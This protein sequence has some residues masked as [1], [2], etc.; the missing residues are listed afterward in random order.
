MPAKKPPGS[1]TQTAD[2]QMNRVNNI[3]NVSRAISRMQRD[4]DQKIA[5]TKK[6]VNEGREFKEIHDTMNKTLGSLNSTIGALTGGITRITAD[7]ARATA[8]AIKQYGQAISQDIS[9]NKKNVVAMALAQT[10]P[11]YGYFVA[12]FME[13]D[14]FKRALTRM[15]T[16]IGQTIGAVVRPFKGKATKGAEIPHMQK[17]GTVKAGGLAKLHAGETVIP[18]GMGSSL[19]EMVRLQKEQSIYL[20]SV[21]GSVPPTKKTGLFGMFAKTLATP[22]KI[23]KY[24]RRRKGNYTSDLSNANMPL[25]NIAQNVATLYTQLMWRLDN[26]LEI[27]KANVQANRDLATH[28]TG[29]GYEPIKGISFYR[30]KKP[31]IRTALSFI[32]RRA[33]QLAA[34]GGALALLTGAPVAGAALGGAGIGLGAISGVLKGVAKRRAEKGE[35]GGVAGFLGKERGLYKGYGHPF[36]K[37]IGLGIKR[38]YRQYMPTVEQYKEFPGWEEALTPGTAFKHFEPESEAAKGGRRKM[39]AGMGGAPAGAGRGGELFIQSTVQHFADVLSETLGGEK[40]KDHPVWTIRKFTRDQKRDLNATAEREKKEFKLQKKATESVTKLKDVQESWYAK[41]KKWRWIDKL[42]KWGG[43]L[44]SFISIPFKGLKNLFGGA[45]AGVGLLGPL[46]KYLGIPALIFGGL[47]LWDWLDK[48]YPRGKENGPIGSVVKAIRESWMG[49][50]WDLGSSITVSLTTAFKDWVKGEKPLGQIVEETMKSVVTDFLDKRFLTTFGASFKEW[51]DAISGKSTP[52]KQKETAEKMEKGYYKYKFGKDS[53]LM[54]KKREAISKAKGVKGTFNAVTDYIIS[55]YK[56]KIPFLEP[57]ESIEEKLKAAK[58]LTSKIISAKYG[59]SP[60][61]ATLLVD[62]IVRDVRKEGI[63]IEEIIESPGGVAQFR[64]IAEQYV[65]KWGFKKTGTETPGK[66]MPKKAVETSEVNLRAAEV[67]LGY[68]PIVDA[69]IE[70]SEKQ[71][72]MTA[73]STGAIITSQANNTT[74]I[75]T[76][77]QSTNMGNQGGNPFFSNDHWSNV[78]ISGPR[79]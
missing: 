75:I 47:T 71:R 67:K 60:S 19:E 8:Q 48:I 50:T 33:P 31:L 22:F 6:Q 63:D 62:K 74:S 21:F 79:Q 43:A 34:L 23:V 12:K 40:G 78:S 16:A 5:E 68:T 27:M 66:G 14:V 3:S 10:S 36:F 76:N 38:K 54:L 45:G 51:L 42:L 69:L 52:E 24:F 53:E 29:Q 20:R 30:R 37:T 32:V 11:L 25:D 70:E 72:K 49:A 18:A 61:R 39:R 15:K 4:V 58:E 56:S 41:V 57:E 9:F 44:L 28:F 65:K 55:G 2:S 13:T 77:N 17:G 26:M 1:I 7:T 64:N 46:L 35:K 59:I 73:T